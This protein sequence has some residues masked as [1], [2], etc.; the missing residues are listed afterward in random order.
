MLD[1]PTFRPYPSLRRIQTTVEGIMSDQVNTEAR[2]S[3]LLAGYLPEAEVAKQLGKTTRYLRSRR[4]QGLGPI[5]IKIGKQTYYHE[6]DFRQWLE[7][8]AVKP[9]RSGRAA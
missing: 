7:T 3:R 5:Y 6:T 8:I 2:V 1:E 4:A 9:V